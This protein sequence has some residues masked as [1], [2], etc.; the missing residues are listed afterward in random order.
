MVNT[1]L[2]ERIIGCKI[3]EYK[4]FEKV[5]IDSPHGIYIYDKSEDKWIYVDA[6]RDVFIPKHDG[7]YII[8][9]DN[10]K[11]PACRVYDIY[12][13]PYVSL[14]GSS[15]ENVYFV[16]IL[17]EWF[18]RNC[19]SRIASNTFKY[20]EI[21]ASPT[22]LLLCIKNGEVTDQDKVEG[23]KTMDKLASIVEEFARKNGFM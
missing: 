18:A 17:C 23:V 2:L 21:H 16:I 1:A 12:W 11:C 19:R 7:I 20:F 10:T 15:L 4:V 8:Y 5:D 22:T 9:F 13:F 6:E 14:L 3:K